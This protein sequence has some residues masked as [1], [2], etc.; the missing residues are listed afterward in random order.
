MD[1]MARRYLPEIVDLLENWGRYFIGRADA[2][3]HCR[4]IEHRYRPISDGAE[5]ECPNRRPEPDMHSA[6]LIEKTL[7]NPGFPKKERTL[8]KWEFLF[9]NRNGHSRHARR[10]CRELGVR[11]GNDGEQYKI[12]IYRACLMLKNRLAKKT[13]HVYNVNLQVSLSVRAVGCVSTLAG[14]EPRRKQAITR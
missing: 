2:P 11:Y 7:C 12:E 13:G 6:V 4:S 9:Y 10:I 1:S 14:V 3:G 5:K 8:I